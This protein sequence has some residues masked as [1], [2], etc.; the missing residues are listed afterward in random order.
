M[1]HK[2]IQDSGQALVHQSSARRPDDHL[3]LRR[4]LHR[5][6]K[7]RVLQRLQEVQGQ[8][9]GQEPGGPKKTL[10]SQRGNGGT[11]KEINEII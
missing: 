5:R 8:Q 6:R 3:L 10:G 9:E 2:A 11:E 1:A 4:G 7:W